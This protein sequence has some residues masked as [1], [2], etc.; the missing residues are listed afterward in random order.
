MGAAVQEGITGRLELIS[1][2]SRTLSEARLELRPMLQTLV[3]VLSERTGDAAAVALIDEDGALRWEEAQTRAAPR[4]AWSKLLEAGAAAARQLTREPLPKSLRGVEA[5]LVLIP[6]RGSRVLGVVALARLGSTL[7]LSEEELALAEQLIERAALSFENAL[8]FEQAQQA[9]RIRD[10]FLSVA[11]HELRTPLTAL[12]LHVAA[13]KRGLH[14]TPEGLESRLESVSRQTD[15][16]KRLVEGL[17]DVSRIRAGR[18]TLD[19]QRLELTRLA[20]EILERNATELTVS[21][22]SAEL[23]YLE[24]V[25]VQ[26]DRF[27]LEQVVTNLLSN[28]IKYGSGRPISLSV[29]GEAE[30]VCLSVTDRGIGISSEAQARVF[31]RFERAVSGQHYAG[32][33]LGLWIVRQ[34]MEAMGGSIRV[35][36]VIG[37]GSTFVISLPRAPAP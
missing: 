9:V 17:L 28:A 27:Q 16:L 36:S 21:G 35:E 2:L 24:P 7:P 10:E 29:W 22:S 6:V 15:R 34:T 12:H 19:L 1:E 18:L 33:G 5:G 25:Y 4:E 20:A 23:S 14:Q 3:E 31:E 13:L 30:R 8:L 26:A 11:G 32:L 37:E